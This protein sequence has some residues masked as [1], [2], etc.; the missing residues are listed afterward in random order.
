MTEAVLPVSI[1]VAAKTANSSHSILATFRGEEPVLCAI[2]DYGFNT[3]ATLTDNLI[4]CK[5]NYSTDLI[6]QLF[7]KKKILIYSVLFHL[8][9]EVSF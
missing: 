1:H 7:G 9:S 8:H 3:P 4:L 2:D 5:G 6:A